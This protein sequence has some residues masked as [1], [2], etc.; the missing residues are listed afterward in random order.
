VQPDDAKVRAVPHE[1]R[2]HHSYTVLR[3]AVFSVLLDL[4]ERRGVLHQVAVLQSTERAVR[5]VH[6][7]LELR[8]ND[9][10]HLRRQPAMRAVPG[11]QRLLGRDSLLQRSGRGRR[12]LR[13]MPAEHPVPDAQTDLH[14]RQVHCLDYGVAAASTAAMQMCSALQVRPIVQSALVT[15]STQVSVVV[16]HLRTTAPPPAT[17]PPPPVQLALDRHSTQRIV[18]VLQYGAAPPPT[19]PPPPHCASDVQV[20]THVPVVMSHVVFI[21]VQLALPAH[22]TH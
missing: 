21:A 2:L 16:S 19:P 9:H 3:P 22:S 14:E 13:A 15:H 6:G 18:V 7:Q 1:L 12:K 4:H 11:K 17:P 8:R 10:A 20:A 5:S